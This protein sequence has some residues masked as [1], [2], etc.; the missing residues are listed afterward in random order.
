[1]A[2]IDI[3]GLDR[4]RKI[5]LS[6]ARK[7]FTPHQPIRSGTLFWGR[8]KEVQKIIEHL[9]TPGQH[10]VLY[11]DRGVGKSSLANIA[12]EVLLSKIIEGKVYPKRCDSQDTF[13]S[14]VAGPL[15]AR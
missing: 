4:E 14:I 12:T 11:G 13:G 15:A 7:V 10:A 9:N 5:E 2:G 3:F 1:M 8:Q 6:G